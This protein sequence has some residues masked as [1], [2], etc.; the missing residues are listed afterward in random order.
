MTGETLLL[1]SVTGLIAGWL[2]SKVVG[3]GLG[4]IGDMVVG[5]AGALLGGALFREFGIAV[6]FSGM[7]SAVTV[8]FVGAVVLLA[9][10][11][12]LRRFGSA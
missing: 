6:P 9:V 3:G 4:L 10:L 2:A 12:A 8:A 5:M 1:W 11:R 7:A